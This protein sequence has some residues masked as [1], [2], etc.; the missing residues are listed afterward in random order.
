MNEMEDQVERGLLE[1]FTCLFELIMHRILF[2][3]QISSHKIT[4]CAVLALSVF[5]SS[6]WNS[7]SNPLRSSLA[8]S[9]LSGSRIFSAATM[10]TDT[11]TV[12]QIPCLSDNYGTS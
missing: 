11:F 4:S 1:L 10:A 5:S 8:F 3:G 9:A 7:A 12:A 6:A 2:A